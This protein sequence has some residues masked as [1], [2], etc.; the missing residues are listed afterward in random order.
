MVYL[1]IGRSKIAFLKESILIILWLY[2]GLHPFL[3]LL[4]DFFLLLVKKFAFK[5]YLRSQKSILG[6]FLYTFLSFPIKISD[7][8]H[9]PLESFL[10]TLSIPSL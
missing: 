4:V 1:E 10:L 9:I 3:C 7:Y 5:E 8:E 6:N 2:Y